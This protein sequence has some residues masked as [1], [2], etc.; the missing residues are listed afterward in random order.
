MSY[1]SHPTDRRRAVGRLAALATAI[2]VAFLGVTL[3]GVT[4]GEAQRWVAGAG[5]AGPVIFVLA[6]GA[7]GLA[8]FPGHVTATV[9]GMLFGAVAG[10]A[11][12]LAATLLGAGLCLLAGRRLGAHAVLSLLGPRGRRWREWLEANGF[13]AVLACR[14]APGMPSGVVNYLAGLA[15]IRP[16][17]FYAAVALG[18]LPKTIAYVSLGGALA[19]PLSARGAFAVALYV[20]AAAGGALVARRLI[21]SR[22]VAAPA[23]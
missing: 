3:A 21:R 18:A 5:P 11:L 2:A 6:G 15:G 8:L 16:R 22:P 19:D 23:G 4:P 20:A 13:S 14:L 12:A 1:V 9:A 7:L 17:A 10:T